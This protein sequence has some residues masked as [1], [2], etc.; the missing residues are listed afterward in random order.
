MEIGQKMPIMNI[1]IDN[2]IVNNRKRKLNKDKVKELSESFKLL[3]QLEPITIT[4]QNGQYVLL[5]GWH[6]LEAAKLLGWDKI[7]AQLFEGNELE[8]ELVEIDENLMHNDLTVLEQ[9]EHLARRRELI[10]WKNGMNQY[11]LGSEIISPPKSTSEIAKDIGLTERSA[12]YRMQ[13]ARNIVPEVKDAIRDTEIANS[14]T[15]LLELARLSPEKQMEV[16]QS[17][18][19]GALNIKEAKKEANIKNREI[20]RQLI[21]EKGKTVPENERW[22]VWQG[23]IRTWEAP[24][25]YDFIIT[26]PPYPGEYLELYS[27]LANRSLEWLKPGGLL[28]AM[29]GHFYISEIYIRLSE[30]LKYHWTA[31]YLMPGLLKP[32]HQVNVNSSWKPLLIYSKDKYK[33]KM[34]SDVFTSPHRDKKYHVW[35]QSEEG[36]YSIINGICL[37]GQYIL[38]PFCGAGATGVAALRNGNLFD[39]ID[40][41][42]K[43]VNITK[44]RLDEATKTL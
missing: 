23:D 11:S 32:I 2:I 7:D 40:I 17:I 31:V 41:D 18:M 22:N 1:Q 20:Q 15:Q 8:C 10:G 39:G 37:P 16:A 3:G 43:S 21:A 27:V 14:T 30:Y 34:F 4:S 28:I 35:G 36:M 12:Q 29:C 13:A 24:R 25:Q 19:D 5:A 6:R 38:D 42:I 44:G 33:G 26:D 9:G